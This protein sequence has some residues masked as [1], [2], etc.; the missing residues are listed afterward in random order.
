MEWF[1]SIGEGSSRVHIFEMFTLASLQ[2]RL[3]DT[4]DNHSNLQEHYPAFYHIFHCIQYITGCACTWMRTR[5]HLTGGINTA[6]V[7]SQG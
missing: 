2:D 1:C 6:R 5:K 3:A 7:P 4:P